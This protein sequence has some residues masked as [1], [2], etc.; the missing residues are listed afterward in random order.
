MHCNFKPD[1]A[2][3]ICILIYT[4]NL[5]GKSQGFETVAKVNSKHC[6]HIVQDAPHVVTFDEGSRWLWLSHCF[7][8]FK[9]ARSCDTEL[10]E[11]GISSRRHGQNHV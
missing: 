7:A 2:I 9:F 5:Y 1:R 10:K 3:N 4:V 6:P 8:G 11:V